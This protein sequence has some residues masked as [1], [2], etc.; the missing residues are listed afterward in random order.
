MSS[1]NESMC[2]YII[3]E[4]VQTFLSKIFVATYFVVWAFPWYFEGPCE[5]E[6]FLNPKIFYDKK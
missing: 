6:T 1:R 4:R 2:K 5:N 3:G